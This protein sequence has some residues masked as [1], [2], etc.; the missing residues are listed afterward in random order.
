MAPYINSGKLFL[1]GGGGAGQGNNGGSSSSSPNA[2]NDLNYG[3]AGGGIVIIKA[4][5]IRTTWTGNNY[6]R[7][8]GIIS[9][10]A[11]G[12]SA[13]NK[14]EAPQNTVYYDGAGGGGGVFFITNADAVIW[15]DQLEGLNSSGEKWVYKPKI[16][17]YR[18]IY[19]EAN[20]DNCTIELDFEILVSQPLFIPNA[21]SPNGDGINDYWEIVGLEK[22][23]NAQISI[24]N[25]WG[26][27]IH[28]QFGPG[29]GLI[30]DG[31]NYPVGTYYYIIT[32]GDELSSTAQGAITI[33]K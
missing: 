21:F 5:E 11:N 32:L 1:G 26:A 6:P 20:K 16:G 17:G 15:L 25:R 30:W 12:V 14:V 2:N 3:G 31:G 8:G 33:T 18:T 22:F 28:Q 24:F 9:I 4:D 23:K 10:I 27:K 7:N 29:D 13:S 19:I